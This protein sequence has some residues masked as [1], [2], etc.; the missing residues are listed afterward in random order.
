MRTDVRPLARDDGNDD[1]HVFAKGVYLDHGHQR[2]DRVGRALPVVGRVRREATDFTPL[3]TCNIVNG[4]Q[5][6]KFGVKTT[7]CGFTVWRVFKTIY[8]FY[9]EVQKIYQR[10]RLLYLA[11][12][13]NYVLYLKSSTMN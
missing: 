6:F 10:P 1:E 9:P 12:P 3:G 7:E 2:K 4:P 5:C 8:V 13:P 11:S